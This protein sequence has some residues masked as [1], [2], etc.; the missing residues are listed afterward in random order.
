MSHCLRSVATA[1]SGSGD[2]VTLIVC[3][4]DAPGPILSPRWGGAI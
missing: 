4:Q 3:G 2:E 1:V